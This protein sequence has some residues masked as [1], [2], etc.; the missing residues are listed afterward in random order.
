MYLKLYFREKGELKGNPRDFNGVS[1]LNFLKLQSEVQKDNE[2][3]SEILAKNGMQEKF[4][5][6][7]IF[8][9][10]NFA[11]IK[12]MTLILAFCFTQTFEKIGE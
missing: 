2:E 1:S 10:R 6:K 12:K 5:P 8:W 11:K 9:L 7:N 3:V 4:I